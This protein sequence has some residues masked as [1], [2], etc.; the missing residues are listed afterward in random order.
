VDCTATQ[1]LEPPYL[2]NECMHG[3]LT[4]SFFSGFLLHRC[5]ATYSRRTKLGMQRN[6]TPNCLRRHVGNSEMDK[7]KKRT[8]HYRV[9]LAVVLELDGAAGANPECR[10]MQSYFAPLSNSIQHLDLQSPQSNLRFQAV[11]FYCRIVRLSWVSVA[12]FQVCVSTA[13]QH[14]EFGCYMA[15]AGGRLRPF[16]LLINH[17]RERKPL[18][19]QSKG[20]FTAVT[21]TPFLSWSQKELGI[22]TCVSL[23]L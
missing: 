6:L 4:T 15:H 9:K 20:I 23:Q 2:Q 17:A 22:V 3:V 12:V 11:I 14:A 10:G 19:A 13:H 21:A 18:C 7:S 5:C 16:M 1:V 8:R